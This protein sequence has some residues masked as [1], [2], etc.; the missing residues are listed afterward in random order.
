MV[1]YRHNLDSL[2]GRRSEW[3]IVHL[4]KVMC[5]VWSHSKIHHV[6]INKQWWIFSACLNPV[7]VVIIIPSIGVIRGVAHCVWMFVLVAPFRFFLNKSVTGTFA[8][9]KCVRTTSQWASSARFL[10]AICA[11]LPRYAR[12]LQCTWNLLNQNHATFGAVMCE[13]W[14]HFQLSAGS[15][16][17]LFSFNCISP[18][19]SFIDFAPPLRLTR[20]KTKTNGDLDTRLLPC[21]MTL[22]C[23]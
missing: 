18:N 20:W 19:A 13:I 3:A 8:W 22:A 10:C 5:S 4:I 12:T 17:D 16:P 7:R 9:F 6:T 15:N 23:V 21:L 14:S 1:S 11:R 2:R